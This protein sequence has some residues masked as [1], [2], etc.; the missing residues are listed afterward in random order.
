M[1][2]D[3]TQ[4]GSVRDPIHKSDLNGIVG[5]FGCTE[6]FARKKAERASG[7]RTYE[8]ANGKLCTGNAVH[9][10]IARIL[11]SEPARAGALHP[12][13]TFPESTIATAFKEEFERQ[14][15]G[16]IVDWYKQ[17]A[18]KWM[19]EQVQLLCGLLNDLHNHVGEV[20]LVEAGFI[21][22][23][24]GI[25]L[26]GATDLVYRPP[27]S[28]ELAFCDWKTGAQRPHQ[29]DLDH[30]WE[31]GIYAGALRDAWFI[32]GQNVHAPEG[33]EHRDA[34]EAAC[35]EL[36]EAWQRAGLVSP[37]QESL[38][39]VEADERALD[40]VVLNYDARY[41]GEFP[42]R[43]RHVHLR[44]YIPYSRGGSKTPTAAEDL[45]WHRLKRPEKIKYVKGDLR[46]PA[47][48]HVQRSESDVPRLRH[49]L[50]AVVSWI[51]HGKFAAAPGEM[52]MR[53][54]FREPCLNS[55]YQPIGEELVQLERAT[56]G[57]DFDG[58]GE[59]LDSV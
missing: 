43:I 38:P 35:I 16:R 23:L 57:M 19:A 34:L 22:Q 27:G 7:K 3:H 5:K 10:V 52:C 20:V 1:T 29:I 31:G 12:T 2:W 33:V 54:K 51:R 9:E 26:T 32:P 42:D 13:Y 45:A 25:W 46:G 39:G 37:R 24:D 17:N 58:F 4:W 30:G 40:S 59:G 56:K 41:F 6:Q 11:R 53:C 36:A 49:L 15:A 8:K 55:G 48:L 47:W 28:S 21:Y 44:H 18:E 50:H 14:R